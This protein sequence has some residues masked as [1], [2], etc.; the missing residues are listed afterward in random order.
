[1]AE[2]D[3]RELVQAA[4]ADEDPIGRV[5]PDLL[6]QRVVEKG[7]ERAGLDEGHDASG[8]SPTTSRTNDA[9]ARAAGD[10]GRAESGDR[11]SQRHSTTAGSSGTTVIGGAP[12]RRS[13]A[14]D[15]SI[16]RRPATDPG[17]R[18]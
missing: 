1:S 12:V 7:V 9:M 15:I 5:D 17:E 10:R 11:P 8:H 2:R 3:R 14:S 13:R 16:L 4:A 6:D 18:L